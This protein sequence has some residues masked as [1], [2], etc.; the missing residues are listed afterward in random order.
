MKTRSRSY[1]D[2]VLILGNR[3]IPKLISNDD[4]YFLNMYLFEIMSLCWVWWPQHGTAES[5]LYII[6]T[7]S[8]VYLR[9]GGVA[10]AEVMQCNVRV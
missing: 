10:V 6:E 4:M 3:L 7:V 2:L 1:I 8:Y 9:F 5:L